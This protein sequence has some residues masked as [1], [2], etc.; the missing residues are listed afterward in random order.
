MKIPI[1]YRLI[2]QKLLDNSD[3]ENLIRI[4]KARNLIGVCFRVNHK[5]IN[6][7]MIEMKD[8]KLILFINNQI[9]KVI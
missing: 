9:V 6:K 4:K 7:M 8:L 3:L 5:I 1:P 2:Y